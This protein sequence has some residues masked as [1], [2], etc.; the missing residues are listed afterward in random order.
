MVLDSGLELLNV[1]AWIL[2]TLFC[3][4]SEGRVRSMALVASA[5]GAVAPYAPR[6]QGLGRAVWG[7]WC[8]GDHSPAPFFLSALVFLVFQVLL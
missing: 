2:A 1:P 4:L 3:S 5:S 7:S 8:P 6:A